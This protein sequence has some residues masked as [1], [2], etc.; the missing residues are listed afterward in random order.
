MIITCPACAKRYLIADDAVPPEGRRVRCATCG[1]AWHQDP[2]PAPAAV[3]PE[4]AESPVP[5]PPVPAN[6]VPRPVAAAPVRHPE[7]PWAQPAPRVGHVSRHG[8]RRSGRRDPARLWNAAAA[9]AGALLLALVLLAK[10]GGVA[11]YDP[12]ARLEPVPP[13]VL[14]LS[15]DAP[16]IGPGIDGAAV[17]TLFGRMQNP[18]PRPQSVP[19]LNVEVRDEGGSILARWTSPPPVAE[20]GAGMTLTFE[21]A[22]GGIPATARTARLAFGAHA[23]KAG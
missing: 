23:P 2:A 13:N 19:P 4:P 21:T 8:K 10:P 20:I 7:E 17:L 14:R 11:G 18:S 12:F 1:N 9:G 3:K 22:A 16:V 15:V 5:A 6:P